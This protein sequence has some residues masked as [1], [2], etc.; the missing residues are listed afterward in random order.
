M[1]QRRQLILDNS[2]QFDPNVVDLALTDLNSQMKVPV[3]DV[4]EAEEM[5]K[6]NQIELKGDGEESET[7]TTIEQ[8]IVDQIVNN[9]ITT[10]DETNPIKTF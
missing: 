5:M 9:P 7:P 10:D 8:P 3:I 6:K 1:F 4:E 2:D